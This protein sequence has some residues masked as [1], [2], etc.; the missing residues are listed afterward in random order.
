MVQKT[1]LR[2]HVIP[3]ADGI[4]AQWDFNA[5][6]M[7]KFFNANNPEGVDVDGV[8]DEAYGNF[9]DPCNERWDD[10]GR[11]DIDRT[12]RSAY[13][14]LGVCDLTKQL[15]DNDPSGNIDH[16]HLSMDP[17]DLTF[18]DANAALGWSQTS[19]PWGTI[20]DRIHS[21]VTDLTPGG[22]VQSLAAVPYYRDDAC[23]DDGTGADPGPELHP[24]HFEE[25][26]ASRASDGSARRCWTPEDGPTG[27]APHGDARGDDRFW[28][29]DIGTHGLHILFLVDSDNAR[30]TVPLTEMVSDWDL[31][32]LPPDQTWQ[33]GQAVNVGERYGRQF[34]KPLVTVVS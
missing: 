31:I 15:A 18:A 32:M 7:T 21:E 17:G 4:Y 24:R 10:N 34:E 33:D 25:E 12:Y 11:T 1:W 13:Q 16:Y 30:T 2:V 14:E 23:F 29:G 27:K 9:D 26:Q 20:V 6:R 19:G 3:P 22:A 28:Q 5:G 8:N